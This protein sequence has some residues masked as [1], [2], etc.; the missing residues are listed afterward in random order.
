MRKIPKAIYLTSEE[1]DECIALREAEANAMPPG[2]A[3][4]SILKELAQL[5]SYADMKRWCAS[6]LGREKPQTKPSV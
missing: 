4:Q 3:R 6:P 1:I 2:A 5:R